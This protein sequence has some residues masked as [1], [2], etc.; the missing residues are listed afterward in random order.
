MVRIMAEWH[1]K[2]G[3]ITKIM[4]LDGVT[5]YTDPLALV[6]CY[7][8]HEFGCH[9]GNVG[10]QCG[11]TS[12]LCNLHLGSHGMK[13]HKA[14]QTIYHSDNSVAFQGEWDSRS[15]YQAISSLDDD[16]YWNGRKVI[17]LGANTC[18]L[19]IEI[20]RRGAIV[21]ACE[22]DPYK[23][24]KLLSRSVLDRVIADENL[25]VQLLD[26]PLFEIHSLENFEYDTIL[27]LGLIYHFRDP[28]YVLDY[29]SS[30]NHEELIIST[31]THPGE[32]LTL[33]NR[34]DPSVI[35]TKN[36]WDRHSD[37]I[38]GWHPTRAMFLASLE[39][40]GYDDI[41]PL[42]NET[43]NFPKKP[44]GLTNSAYYKA[45]HIRSMDA[46]KSRE[47]FYPR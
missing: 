39:S 20:A 16:E 7:D 1:P 36:F 26:T 5:G 28:Q 15:L 19:S 35:K 27:C 46:V 6:L 9:L 3:P 21:T 22:P 40:A 31:Q 38:S 34:K 30:M 25:E 4:L 43:F 37:S 47:E 11:T 14:C 12:H 2:H 24:N 10:Q 23:N 8:F 41:R 17:D 42:T 18:G 33:W 44:T 45:T 29:I 13:L 32:S